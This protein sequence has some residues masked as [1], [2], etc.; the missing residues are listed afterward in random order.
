MA[1]WGGR[2]V[3]IERRKLL[4]AEGR[5]AERFSS[6][7]TKAL[8]IAEFQILDFGGGDELRAG[9]EVLPLASGFERVGVDAVLVARDAEP[10]AADAFRSIAD[11]LKNAGLPVPSKPFEISGDRGTRAGVYLFPGPNEAETAALDGTL[12]DLCAAILVDRAGANCVE[13]F[14]QCCEEE[15]CGVGH[16]HKAFLHAYFSAHDRYVGRKLGEAAQAG[17]FNRQHPRLRPFSDMLRELSK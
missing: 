4:V 14:L 8:G 17:A 15:G 13:P 7:L 3:E 9:L 1:K 10:N 2:P 12:E 6:W 16:R 5:D 11:G